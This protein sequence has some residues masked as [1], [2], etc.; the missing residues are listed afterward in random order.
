M[1]WGRL[2][3]LAALLAGCHRRPADASDFA[4][5]LQ[6]KVGDTFG[7]M[8][9]TSV[10][11]EG[12][13]LVLTFDGPPNWRLG[14]PGYVVTAAFLEGFCQTGKAKT[15]FADGRTLRLDTTEGGRLPTQGESVSHCP[16]A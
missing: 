11:A 3:L 4:R 14:N 2:F 6:S 16:D 5:E 10:E 9:L 15:Y 13:M 8:R 7:V 12:N 1:K